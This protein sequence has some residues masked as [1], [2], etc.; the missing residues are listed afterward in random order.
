MSTWDLIL[1]D[2]LAI[3]PTLEEG[4]I[5]S[6]VTSPPYADQRHYNGS[7]RLTAREKSRKQRREAP[8]QFVDWL[9]PFLAAMKPLLSERGS[10]MLNLG[11]V[12]RNGE[13]SE[14]ADEV[15]RRARHEQGWKLLHR[16]VWS[17][18]NSLPPSHHA[19]LHISH[20]HVFWLAP[21]IRAYRGYDGGYPDGGGEAQYDPRT[22]RRRQHSETSLRRINDAYMMRKDERYA[23]RGKAHELH[24][25][26]P[27]PQTVLTYG[28]GGTRGLKHP[29]VMTLGLADELVGMSCPPGGVVL[30]PFAGSCTTGV[31]AIGSGRRF[32][33]IEQN[34]DY[35]SEAHGRLQAQ[36]PQLE[37]LS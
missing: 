29:A 33:G 5:D 26:G 8:M 9:M 21:S 23:K 36:T 3:M 27:K 37:G 17:K 25:D 22:R 34:E 13:E 11:V 1:G 16:M 30:D 14:Y 10:L 24:P 20:E 4:S 7:V 6:I 12:M 32:L 19:Y 28:V 2:S 15:L 31:A 35:I 18:E